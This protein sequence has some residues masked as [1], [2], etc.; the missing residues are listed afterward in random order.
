MFNITF[1]VVIWL[2]GI[3]RAPLLPL[4][5][6]HIHLHACV[7]THAHTHACTHVRTYAGLGYFAC[8]LAFYVACHTA[9][10]V[11]TQFKDAVDKV[12]SLT[13]FIDR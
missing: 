2:R 3:P 4:P 5:S 11:V 10:Q 7:H 13:L 8:W 1:R 12:P 6:H 9:Y